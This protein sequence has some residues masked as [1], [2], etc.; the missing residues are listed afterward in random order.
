MSGAGQQQYGQGSKKG[1]K[2]SNGNVK[3]KRNTLPCTVKTSRQRS[4]TQRVGC[5]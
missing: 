1:K 4:F 2:E 3:N 5:R